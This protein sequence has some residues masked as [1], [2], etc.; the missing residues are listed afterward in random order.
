MFQELGGRRGVKASREPGPGSCGALEAFPKRDEATGGR[1]AGQGAPGWAGGQT[2]G[3]R[4]E[5]GGCQHGPGRRGGWLE[6]G[7]DNKEWEAPGSNLKAEQLAFSKSWM[8][9]TR[10]R[11]ARMT[12]DS[13]PHR[14]DGWGA[15]ERG[16]GAGRRWGLGVWSTLPV[17]VSLFGQ[18]LGRLPD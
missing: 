14:E 11:G 9:R 6:P 4:G 10:T 3:A 5:R 8:W 2:V 17:S 18:G 13:R 7:G 16:R 1:P 15:R 12:P